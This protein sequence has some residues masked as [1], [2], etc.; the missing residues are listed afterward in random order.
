MVFA[1]DLRVVLAD[2]TGIVAWLKGV[3]ESARNAQG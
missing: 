3:L 2:E 1:V